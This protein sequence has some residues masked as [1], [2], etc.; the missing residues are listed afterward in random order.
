MQT[1]PVET[2][3]AI[4]M[5]KGLPVVVVHKA[6]TVEFEGGESKKTYPKNC[7]AIMPLHGLPQEDLKRLVKNNYISIYAADDFFKRWI[8]G[9]RSQFFFTHLGGGI[10]DMIA[11]SAMTYFLKN[12]NL[13]V[14]VDSLFFPVFEWFEYKPIVKR[15]D[16]IIMGDYTP[17]NRLGKYKMIRRLA[18][19]YA[20]VQGRDQNWYDAMFER[21]GMPFAPDIYARPR[22]IQHRLNTKPATVKTKESVLIQHKSSCQMRSS[23]FMDFFIPVKKVYKNH[24]IYVFDSD[25]T[26][27]EKTYLYNMCLNVT[28]IPKCDMA[29]YLLNLYDVE[30][31]VSVDTGAIHFREG[32]GKRCL[33]V[34]GAMSTASRTSGYI[35]TK[36]FDVKSDCPF[37]P[38]FKHELTKGDHC[39]NSL[40]TDT[41]AKCLTGKD[42]QQQLY[43]NLLTYNQ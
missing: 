9:D 18:M 37:Q 29:T 23:T 19:E 13:N 15:F 33:A 41:T 43:E 36:S 14:Y 38:C 25:L 39:E 21:I 11:F 32:I 31:V 1:E 10:G 22:L 2:D 6:V 26:D 42:F 5:K 16:E 34:F 40:E 7:V 35:Y 3:M 8:Y 12:K 24:D 4:T 28:I 27:Q 17:Q 30:M 20:A